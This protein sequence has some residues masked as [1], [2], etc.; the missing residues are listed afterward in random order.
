MAGGFFQGGFGTLLASLS[1]AGFFTYVLPFLI[2]F[3]L[4][5]G[6]LLRLK[7]FEQNKA[8]DGIISLSVALLALQ[9]DMVP[10]FFSELFPRVGVA[11]AII[12]AI[13]IL[14]GL[15]V[16]VN[17]AWVNYAL[18]G[19]VAVIIIAVFVKAS[20]AF[21]TGWDFRYFFSQYGPMLIAVVF[22]IV[23]VAIIMNAGKKKEDKGDNPMTIFAKA[24][25]GGQS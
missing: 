11:L 16:P 1:E 6:I 2:L 21:G 9:F 25:S 24:L 4:I 17:L 8:I 10:R 23:V 5:Y 22:I 3:A 7:V 15:F 13:M 14:L 20:N 19:I 18:L 12:L